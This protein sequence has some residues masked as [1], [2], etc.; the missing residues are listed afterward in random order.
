MENKFYI[1]N[2]TIYELSLLHKYS[3]SNPEKME[4]HFKYAIM[5]FDSFD[6]TL[7][8]IDVGTYRILTEILGFN[9]EDFY[10][11]EITLTQDIFQNFLNSE[12]SLIT[13]DVDKY[14]SDLNKKIVEYITDKDNIILN[15]MINRN[16]IKFEGYVFEYEEETGSLSVIKFPNSPIIIIPSICTKI[17]YDAFSD[18]GFMHKFYNFSDIEDMN[19]LFSGLNLQYLDLSSFDFRKVNNMQYF[20]HNTRIACVNF[21]NA[22]FSNC[23]DFQDFL[24]SNYN[25]PSYI[26]DDQ[27]PVDISGF[28]LNPAFKNANSFASFLITF[29]D[30]NTRILLSREQMR[31]AI[32]SGFYSS[33]SSDLFTHNVLRIKEDYYAI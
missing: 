3:I 25:R 16:E 6:K 31:L 24:Y 30:D 20:L 14:A 33:Y 1:I 10:E 22:D 8:C 11:S 28:I 12:I 29:V 13:D 19:C 4:N 26:K 21:G 7:S 2:D 18:I 9:F 5:F 15:R 23:I 17:D 27:I 32:D